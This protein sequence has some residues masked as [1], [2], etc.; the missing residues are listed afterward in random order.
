[1]EG[2]A[3][4]PVIAASG[5]RGSL[6]TKGEVGGRCGCWEQSLSRKSMGGFCF[7]LWTTRRG[8]SLT[9][10]QSTNDVVIIQQ[11]RKSYL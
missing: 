2:D 4:A 7:F 3:R 8:T 1:M 6:A 9:L 11:Q 10:V 5:L